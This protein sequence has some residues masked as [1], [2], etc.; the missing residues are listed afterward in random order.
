[1]LRLR[2]TYLM[3]ENPCLALCPITAFLQMAFADGAFEAENLTPA[4]FF[5]LQVPPGAPSLPVTFKPSILETPLF[6]D[7]DGDVLKYDAMRQHLIRLGEAAGF[8]HALKPYC[9]RRGVANA[10]HGMRTPS[11]LGCR[12]ARLTQAFVG[13]T[14]TELQNQ[15]LRHR[16]IRT[17]EK[18]CQKPAAAA[19][20]PKH[21][22][23]DP[24]ENQT[25]QARFRHGSHAGPSTTD[26]DQ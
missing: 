1:M 5:E 22:L 18:Y 25:A 11:K 26:D 3:Q 16:N 17:F 13:N 23:G 7:D 15:A 10:I 2:V 21:L 9:F 12:S 20:H 14:T 6:R 4:K 8:E 19:R 24:G